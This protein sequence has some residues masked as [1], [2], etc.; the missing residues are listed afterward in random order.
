MSS[1]TTNYNLHKIDLTDAP[2]DITVLNGNWDTIDS[3]LKGRLPLT[4]GT[5]TGDLLFAKVNNG[6]ASIFKNH[7][8]TSDYGLVLRDK[9]SGN[10][11]A[12]L[13]INATTGK[14]IFTK[15]STAYEVYHAGNLPLNT[16]VALAVVG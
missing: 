12:E 3:E 11:T 5:I 2:P 10:A 4:G 9:S 14:V 13:S 15:D 6:G 8:S 7:N 16:E 1:K